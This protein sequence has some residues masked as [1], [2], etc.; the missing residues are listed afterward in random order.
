MSDIFSGF[1]DSPISPSRRG[2]TVTPNDNADLP[3][4]TKEI[5]ATGAGNISVIMADSPTPITIPFAAG[6][7]RAIRVVR[8]RAAGTTA[9]GI[10]AFG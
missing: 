1:S 8:I 10:L 2:V 6:E 9:T 7:V 5:Q 4:M 3:F